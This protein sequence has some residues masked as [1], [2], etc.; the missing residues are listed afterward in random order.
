MTEPDSSGKDSRLAKRFSSN[1]RERA[2]FEAGIKL[3]GL[4]HQFTGIPLS[5]SNKEAVERAMEASVLVQPYVEEVT[6]EIRRPLHRKKEEFDYTTLRGEDL[7][8]E[9]S[10]LFEGVRVLAVLE[11]LPK[12]DYPLMYIRDISEPGT[13][14]N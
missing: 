5:L 2:A 10:L 9:L 8:V 1:S 11:Y 12:E 7:Y 4:F 3:G 13:G 6:V 14:R